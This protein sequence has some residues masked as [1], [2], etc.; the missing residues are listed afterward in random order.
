MPNDARPLHN[1]GISYASRVMI[2]AS[3]HG[4][5]DKANVEDA[6]TIFAFRTIT[7]E[8]PRIPVVCEMRNRNN[9]GLLKDS[10]GLANTA[11][12]K[13]FHMFDVYAAGNVYNSSTIDTLVAQSFY[14]P[15][16]IDVVALLVG[17]F[18]RKQPWVEGFMK[19]YGAFAGAQLVYMA[20]PS[21]CVNKQYREVFYYLANL[22]AIPLGL[23]RGVYPQVSRKS[24]LYML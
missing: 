14:N 2:F 7:Q 11:Q 3:A 15:F 8:N 24:F 6:D 12:V 22:G 19:K 1:A 9:I 23:H 21:E 16:A 4:M 20:V 17:G 10:S 18:D 5:N 13:P